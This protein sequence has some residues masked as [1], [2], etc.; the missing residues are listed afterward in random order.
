MQFLQSSEWFFKSI[1]FQ[2]NGN[3]IF[4]KMATNDDDMYVEQTLSDRLLEKGR[5]SPFLVAS[6]YAYIKHV[7]I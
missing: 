1:T 2:V 3:W 7:K 6:M 4:S 5:K